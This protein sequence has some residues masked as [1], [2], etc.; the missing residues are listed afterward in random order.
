MSRVEIKSKDVWI[1]NPSIDLVLVTSIQ[2][3]N[4]QPQAQGEAI[5]NL[6]DQP[7]INNVYKITFTKKQW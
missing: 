1:N 2:T 6:D 3:L 4:I 7:T 5:T